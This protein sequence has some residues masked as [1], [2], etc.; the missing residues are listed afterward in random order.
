[1]KINESKT[2]ILM[3]NQCSKQPLNSNFEVENQ[4]LAYLGSKKQMMKEARQTLTVEQRRGKTSILR[5]KQ[6]FHGK[7]D[8]SQYQKIINKEFCMESSTLC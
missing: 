8:Q 3:C 5:E 1:M 6:S 2:K 7:H 4:N